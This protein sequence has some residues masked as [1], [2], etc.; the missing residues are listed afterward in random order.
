MNKNKKPIKIIA[1][2]GL[3]AGEK[4]KYKLS[5]KILSE[6]YFSIEQLGIILIIFNIGRGKTL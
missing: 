4:A 2:A 5:V 6:S 1:Q 3:G